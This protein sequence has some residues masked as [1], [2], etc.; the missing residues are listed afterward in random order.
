MICMVTTAGR[1]VLCLSDTS[2]RPRRTRPLSPVVG[3]AL[4]QWHSIRGKVP[5]LSQIFII[6]YDFNTFLCNKSYF[7]IIKIS[8][9]CQLFKHLQEYKP[10]IKQTHWY[11]AVGDH[12]SSRKFQTH[13]MVDISELFFQTLTIFKLKILPFIIWIKD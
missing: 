6:F 11:N 8:K 10:S 1:L 9:F 4:D 5:P 13:K 7:S 12:N 3:S 2:Q